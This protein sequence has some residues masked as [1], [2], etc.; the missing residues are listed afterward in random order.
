M[1]DEKKTYDLSKPVERFRAL[2]DGRTLV[3]GEGCEWAVYDGRF[4]LDRREACT[5]DLGN[6]E[7]RF[8]LKPEKRW[9]DCSFAEAMTAYYERKEKVRSSV[10]G[11]W[12]G[13]VDLLSG[14]LVALKKRKWQR[15]VE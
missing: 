3:D 14:R 4:F 11:V 9:I 1:S 13:E 6:S 12:T 8:S 2:L 7:I 5:E 15:E 10:A